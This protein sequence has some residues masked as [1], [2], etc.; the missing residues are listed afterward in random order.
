MHRRKAQVDELVRLLDKLYSDG[1][2]GRR[3]LG[4]QYDRVSGFTETER[5]RRKSQIPN[6]G[7]RKQ[8]KQHRTSL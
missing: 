1:H 7:P 3:L 5:H 2:E 4:T 8:P 6:F